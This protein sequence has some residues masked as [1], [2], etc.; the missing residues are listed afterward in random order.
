MRLKIQEKIEEKT[1]MNSQ[2]TKHPSSGTLSAIKHLCD[3]L[4]D[5]TE[6][7]TFKTVKQEA[8]ETLSIL[9]KDCFRLEA[10]TKNEAPYRESE[11]DTYMNS[12]IWIPRSK[13]NPTSRN[14]WD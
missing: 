10:G 6:D 2:F 9:T 4:Q 14:I 7:G 13:W 5:I 1:L 8:E 3:T 12:Q 11:Y